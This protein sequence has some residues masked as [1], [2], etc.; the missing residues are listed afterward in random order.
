MQARWGRALPFEVSRLGFQNGCAP[1]KRLQTTRRI[2]D[3]RWNG[4]RRSV[5]HRFRVQKRSQRKCGER[6]RSQKWSQTIRLTSLPIAETMSALLDATSPAPGMVAAA[7][8]DYVSGAEMVSARASGSVPVPWGCFGTCVRLQSRC[9][10]RVRPNVRHRF[11]VCEGFW[12]IVPMGMQDRSSP[13]RAREI[14]FLQREA[15]G[16]G[17]AYEVQ[18]PE[19]GV[20]NFDAGDA[21]S[22]RR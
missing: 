18:N 13:R 9:G 15:G 5:W 22:G 21:T 11:M 4:C 7:A 20:A 6:F 17:E 12:P 2:A 1:M 16:T 3:D 8:A 14:A 10:W 19:V